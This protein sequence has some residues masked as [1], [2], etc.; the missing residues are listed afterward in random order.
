MLTFRKSS[1]FQNSCVYIHNSHQRDGQLLDFRSTFAFLE[2]TQLQKLPLFLAQAALYIRRS[3]APRPRTGDDPRGSALPPRGARR[4]S[5]PHSPL[6]PAARP[7]DPAGEALPTLPVRP[8]AHRER[9]AQGRRSRCGTDQRLASRPLPFP[10]RNSPLL[11]SPPPARTRSLRPAEGEPLTLGDP[12]GLL[13]ARPQVTLH[14]GRRLLL[15]GHG[16]ERSGPRGGQDAAPAPASARPARRQ[17]RPRRHRCHAP[18]S[19]P[20]R[21]SAAG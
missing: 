19:A 17:Q 20:P 2:A 6:V 4:S 3:E 1:Q 7:Q 8:W 11:R 13:V 10:L 14:V 12:L 21:R 16:A 9:R 5:R 18:R 15:R